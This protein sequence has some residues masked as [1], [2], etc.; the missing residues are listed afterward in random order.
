M[1]PPPDSPSLVYTYLQHV[2]I[3]LQDTS[4][5]FQATWKSLLLCGRNGIDKG[6]MKA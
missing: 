4:V 2:P 3:A 6:V 1:K 5:H